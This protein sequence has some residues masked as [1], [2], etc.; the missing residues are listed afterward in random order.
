VISANQFIA[1]IGVNVLTASHFAPYQNLAAVEAG[2]N[3]VGVSSLR[4]VALPYTTSYETLASHGFKFDFFVPNNNNLTGG[5]VDLNGTLSYL[6]SFQTRHPGSIVSIEGANEINAWPVNYGGQ[7]GISAAVALQNDLFSG[8]NAIGNL[9][10]ISVLN[11][12]MALRS[13]Q[14][15]EAYAPLGNLSNSADKGNAH[16]YFN[17]QP[18]SLYWDVLASLSDTPT[19]GLSHDVITETGYSSAYNDASGRS[20]S[21]IDQAKLTLN[22]LML[23][24]KKGVDSTFLYQLVD[25]EADPTH[26]DYEAGLGLFRSDWSAKP[27]ADALHNLTSILGDEARAPTSQA[28]LS[29]SVTGMPTTAK[30][31][32]IQES[33][34]IFDLVLWNDVDVWNEASRTENT[35]AAKSVTVQLDRQY[36]SVK[37][38]DPM[39]G[40]SAILNAGSTNT[41]TVSLTDHPLIV[42]LKGA[43]A[44]QGGT[45]TTD[46]GTNDI[47]KGAPGSHVLDGGLGIDTA[48]YAGLSRAYSYS[49]AGGA[50]TVIGGPEGVTDRLV[51]I[52]RV[53]FLD[54]YY[55]TGQ[56]DSAA[57][58]YRAY[59]AALGHAPDA[60]GLGNSAKALDGGGSLL[61]LASGLLGSWEFVNKFGTMSDSQFVTTLYNNALHRAPDATGLANWTNYLSSGHSRADTLASFA[62]SSES[63]VASASAIQKGLWVGEQNDAITARLYDSVFDRKPDS[64]G[65]IAWA[66]ALD[67][68]LNLQKMAQAFVGSPEFQ[69]RYGSLDNAAFVKQIYQN[70]LNRPAE[71]SGFDAWLNFLNTGHT[72]AELV[73]G[74]SESPEHMGITAPYIDQGVWFI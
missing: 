14:G 64:S 66:N 48:Q 6:S 53:K 21:E 68:G 13:G 67:N 55:A 28:D 16:L 47:L 42:E 39:L 9:K 49:V 74:F 29:Y 25:Q 70:V 1:S 26:S 45:A 11:L 51:S 4:A 73:V 62:E 36:T 52:E 19:P 37:V 58:V 69:I 63:V 38:Y 32:V 34:Q 5:A 30:D 18:S 3:Y 35:V 31:F 24:A 50:G 54:G 22:S 59:E 23:A 60:K 56:T 15:A 17:G 2:L 65:L 41:V 8:V 12:T 61:S 33:D 44:P 57:K 43:I 40:T 71:Q 46:P 20:V 27:V 72:R 7:T 10:D